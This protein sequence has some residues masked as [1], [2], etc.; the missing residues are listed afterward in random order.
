ME[1]KTSI[2][3]P[4]HKEKSDDVDL[5]F[6]SV[7]VYSDHARW[8]CTHIGAQVAK[9]HRRHPLHRVIF[10]SDLRHQNGQRPLLQDCIAVL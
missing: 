3:S 7:G 5:M 10:R 8:L 2:L 6:F 1:N 4:L 9:G